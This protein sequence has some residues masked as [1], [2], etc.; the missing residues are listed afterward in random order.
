VERGKEQP[1]QDGPVIG[2]RP[3][4]EMADVRISLGDSHGILALS[5]PLGWI[6]TANIAP[7][8]S[9]SGGLGVAAL[10]PAGNLSG[11]DDQGP[12]DARDPSEH[13]QAQHDEEASTSLVDD[14]Q[15]RHDHADDRSPEAHVPIVDRPA[16]RA[17]PAPPHTPGL[18]APSQRWD[19]CS[20]RRD[21]LLSALGKSPARTPEWN[22]KSTSWLLPDRRIRAISLYFRVDQ[23]I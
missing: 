5:L 1:L 21:S 8:V 14:R 4:V 13:S 22:A 20:S 3:A 19:P 7:G 17:D 10:T 9:I 2:L 23:G 15:R 12:D 11:A 16:L 18:E 6:Y